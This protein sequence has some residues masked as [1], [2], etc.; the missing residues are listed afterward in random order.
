[1]RAAWRA[2]PAITRL[3]PHLAWFFFSVISYFALLFSHDGH[4]HP[5]T[6]KYMKW[7]P[8]QPTQTVQETNKKILSSWGKSGCWWNA[9][10]AGLRS[11]ALAYCTAYI[12]QFSRMSLFIPQSLVYLYFNICPV[13]A[14]AFAAC[15]DICLLLAERRAHRYNDWNVSTTHTHTRLSLTHEPLKIHKYI[16]QPFF[17]LYPS[18]S[19]IYDRQWALKSCL[20]LIC[21]FEFLFVC[22]LFLFECAMA[23]PF[24]VS[25]LNVALFRLHFEFAKKPK[26]TINGQHPRSKVGFGR[27]TQ[28]QHLSVF[29]GGPSSHVLFVDNKN[30][31]RFIYMFIFCMRLNACAPNRKTISHLAREACNKYQAYQAHLFDMHLW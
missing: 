12:I 5:C 16:M 6:I 20:S 2:P 11:N 26:Q 10:W 22:L 17:C 15:F 28:T 19:V 3:S 13:L 24:F 18:M 8:V 4:T 9:R 23:W 7:F 29:V 30:R 1:M 31:V 21:F 14:I 27:M 25:S